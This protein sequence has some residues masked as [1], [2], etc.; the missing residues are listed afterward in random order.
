MRKVSELPT[1]RKGAKSTT[2]VRYDWD[3]IFD[4]DV[5]EMV[6]GE[7]I[8]GSLETWR[9]NAYVAAKRRGLRAT[10]LIS[11]DR[12]YIRAVPDGK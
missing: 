8:P 6:A 12:V 5:I 10:I 1:P 2:A 7:D 11:G 4:G 9:R 3:A